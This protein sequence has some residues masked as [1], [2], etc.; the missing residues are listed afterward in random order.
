MNNIQNEWILS[1]VI[2]TG[3]EQ[4][5]FVRVDE[6]NEIE[7]YHKPENAKEYVWNDAMSLE[8][9]R[10]T[11]QNMVQHGFNCNQEKIAEAK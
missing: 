8:Q 7:L 5:R 10:D 4:W 3:L 6:G 1:K 9:G 11:W 2:R